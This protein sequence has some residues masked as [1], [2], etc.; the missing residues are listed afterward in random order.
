MAK[1]RYLEDVKDIGEEGEGG[2]RL[3]GIALEE[4]PPV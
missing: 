1:A 2:A 4:N 3:E